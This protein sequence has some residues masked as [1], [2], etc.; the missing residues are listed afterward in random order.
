MPWVGMYDYFFLIP[1]L[2][3]KANHKNILIVIFIFH[4]LN[5]LT[6]YLQLYFN[7]IYLLT[8]NIFLAIILLIIFKKVKLENIKFIN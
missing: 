6:I 8:I 7:N 4:I 2:R 5:S 3:S 1:V